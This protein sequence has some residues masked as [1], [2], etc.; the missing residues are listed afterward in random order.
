MCFFSLMMRA[1]DEALSSQNIDISSLI[2]PKTLHHEGNHER[3]RSSSVNNLAS[4]FSPRRDHQR[5]T[6]DRRFGSILLGNGETQSGTSG[7]GFC[8]NGGEYNAS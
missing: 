2:L 1:A 6:R 7:L 3:H 8:L 4:T 5:K